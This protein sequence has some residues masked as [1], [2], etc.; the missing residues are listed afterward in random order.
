M[1]VAIDSRGAWAARAEGAI[2]DAALATGA[3]VE[4]GFLDDVVSWQQQADAVDRRL[5]CVSRYDVR[6]EWADGHKSGFGRSLGHVSSAFIHTAPS[7]ATNLG[8]P[9]RVR[10]MET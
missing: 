10:E 6:A 4:E 3:G 8:A 2:V 5:P 1:A 9:E 7:I